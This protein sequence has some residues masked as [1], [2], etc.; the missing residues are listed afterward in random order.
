MRFTPAGVPV[1]SC[2]LA[3]NGE[4]AEA[5]G[6]RS[7]ELEIEAIAIGAPSQVLAQV[8]LGTQAW[9]SGFIARKRRQSRMLVFH[10]NDIQVV[11][12]I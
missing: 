10:I 5:N 8:S 7:V 3:Y 6:M 1:V 4:V 2:V 12:Q 11:S 9:F